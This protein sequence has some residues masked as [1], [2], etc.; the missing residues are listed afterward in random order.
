MNYIGNF[1]IDFEILDGFFLLA[2]KAIKKMALSTNALFDLH[3]AFCKFK[4]SSVE[5][6][7]L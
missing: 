2:Y 3:E 1:L 4:M 7:M 5:M 6:R